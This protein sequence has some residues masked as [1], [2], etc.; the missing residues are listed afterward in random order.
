MHTPSD[1]RPVASQ[2]AWHR[3][4]VKR[5]QQWCDDFVLE[6]RMRDVPGSVI[7]DRLA[8]VEA[9]CVETGESPAEAFGPATAYAR[10]LDRETAPGRVSGSWTVGA[11][12]AGNVIALIVGTSAAFPWVRGEELTYNGVQLASLALVLAVLV[13]LPLFLRQ[14][15]EHPWR[16]G[17]PLIILG[18]LG[19]AGSVAAGRLD[20]PTVLTLPAAVVTVG[21][22]VVVL[23]LSWAE[24]R[25]LR[26]EGDG[27]PV[28]S[29][30]A[31]PAA[32]QPRRRRW[33]ILLPALLV[34]IGYVVLTAVAFALG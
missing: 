9:H 13:S 2:E 28:I 7:G 17:L 8:E 25:V 23:V 24:Y 32:V 14:L 1:G 6:L 3:P 18:S 16:V 21:L 30:L 5:H 15:I 29:P 10:R 19:G 34:P 22:F 4:F 12:A 20:L 31:P 26:R 27:D 11:L 33:P